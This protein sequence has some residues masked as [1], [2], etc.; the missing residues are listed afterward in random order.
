MPDAPRFAHQVRA[1][2][3]EV[4][5]TTARFFERNWPASGGGYFRLLPYAM[6]RWLLQSVNRQDRQSAVFYFH[7]WEIDA[8]QP[9]VE[10]VNAKTR[11]RHYVN[12]HRTEGRL[13]RLLADFNWGRMDEIFL[14]NSANAPIVQTPELNS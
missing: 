6:S 5:V 7:P 1:G 12:L 9:R 13:Q 8:G 11:F 10:G 2:L 14:S 3:L 4:P